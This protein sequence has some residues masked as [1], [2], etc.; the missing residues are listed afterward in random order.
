M[1]VEIDMAKLAIIKACLPCH[2]K[3]LEIARLRAY[4]ADNSPCTGCCD[5][6]QGGNYCDC[7]PYADWRAA[8][9]AGKP[10]DAAKGGRDE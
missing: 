1:T 7:E 8:Q 2:E 5:G 10:Q 4:I 6:S 9:S 3:D